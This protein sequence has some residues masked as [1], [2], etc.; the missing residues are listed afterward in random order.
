MCYTHTHTH[1]HT[2][3]YTH[4][5]LRQVACAL[6]P[7]QRVKPGPQKWKCQVLTT[8]PPG[9][10]LHLLCSVMVLKKTKKNWL[11]RIQP[12]HSVRKGEDEEKGPLSSRAGP[13]DYLNFPHNFPFYLI[14]PRCKRSWR[15][16]FFFNLMDL[17]SGLKQGSF[18]KENRGE[19]I[20]GKNFL[21]VVNTSKNQ[22]ILHR[23]LD[24][25]CKIRRW[26]WV[27]GQR[28]KQ[29]WLDWKRLDDVE[30]AHEG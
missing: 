12:L 21:S 3:A 10:S 26:S 18:Y 1:T 6:V 24:F 22:K 17:L 9:N 29:I 25:S 14:H 16:Y 5:W 20:L 19:S 4:I 28:E 2:Q 27:I 30:E 15:M 11:L 8:G 13:G 23:I 7:P